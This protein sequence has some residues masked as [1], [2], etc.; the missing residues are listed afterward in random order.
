MTKTSIHPSRSVLTRR[1]NTL[2][3][4]VEYSGIGIHT[5]R[6]VKLRFCPAKEGTG[7]L[8]QRTDLPSRP[9]I[10][11]GLEYVRDTNRSTTIGL[12]DVFV[13][14]VE[15]VLAA[16]RAYNIDNLLI[17]VSDAEP[18]IANGSSDVFVDMIESAGVVE[19]SHTLPIVKLEKPIYWSQGD[20][21]LI[22]LPDESYR[23]S[24]TLSYPKVEVLRAQYQ[25]FEITPERF[26]T[27]IAA[28]R[29]FSPY[30]ELSTLLDKGLIKGASLSNAVL[31]HREAVFSKGGLFFP[32]EMVRHKILDLIGDLSLIGFNF[33][34]HIIGI[35]TGH[36][37]N[38]EF[39]KKILNHITMEKTE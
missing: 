15:H 26:K 29:T 1:Q 16:I 19:Q 13:H 4:P 38:Y 17:E 23:I 39:A 32:D 33:Q 24:Y 34:A 35:K 3:G 30:E 14:T 8:F 28:C 36:K 10:P 9:I 25:S 2:K 20:S 7:I 21:V 5:G 37:A 27:D 11:A 22:A 31:I 12:T 18:P 6:Q